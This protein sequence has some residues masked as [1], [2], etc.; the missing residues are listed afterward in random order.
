MVRNYRW[1]SKVMDG[2][3]SMSP[4]V[5][6]DKA[7]ITLM[8][9]YK[10]SEGV[11]ASQIINNLYFMEGTGI[12]AHDG[13]EIFQDDVVER[14]CNNPACEVKHRG[15]VMYDDRTGR[16]HIAESNGLAPL[17]VGDIVEGQIK[18]TL[19]IT[20]LGNIHDNPELVDK[21]LRSAIL[22]G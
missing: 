9:S 17:V 5:P 6:L 16:W 14:Y 7:I 13:T 12:P 20:K 15:V 2:K 1:F 18:S 22:E 21:D 4:V 3:D 11:S 10:E 19:G 8:H